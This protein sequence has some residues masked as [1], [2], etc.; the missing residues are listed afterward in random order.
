MKKKV[1]LVAVALCAACGLYAQQQEN[2]DSKYKK[3]EVKDVTPE[4]SVYPCQDRYEAL[5]VIR[6]SEDFELEFK[7]NSDKELNLTREQ[8]GTEKIY[9][10]VFLTRSAG[11]SYRGRKLAI[12]A[13]GYDK[14]YLPLDLKQKERK[15]FIVSDPYSSLR[16]PFYTRADKGLE[17][18][19]QGMYDHALDQYRM[20]QQ[21]PEYTTKR[22]EINRHIAQCDSLIYWTQI[23]DSA[24]V[25][26]DYYLA[27]EYLLKMMRENPKNSLLNDR[28]HSIQQAYVIRCN[29]DMLNGELYMEDGYYDKAKEVYE[30]AVYMRNPRLAE[31]EAKLHEIEKLTYK[32]KNKTRT[33]FYQ[34]TEDTPIS[35]TS[36]G[37]KPNS[38]GGYFSLGF[39]RQAID[40]LS[41][42]NTI[43]EDD[44][45]RLDYVA[46]VSAGWTIPVFRSYVFAFFTPF[47]YVGGGFSME[48]P[49][50]EGEEGTP[51]TPKFGPL[52]QDVHWYHAVAPEAGIVLKYWRIAVNY[53]FQYRYWI[54]QQSDVANL[55][56]TTRHSFGIGFAW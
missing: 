19:N 21:C 2:G 28:L 23:V 49:V 45:P 16:S 44:T 31:A 17:L 42:T 51:A 25:N 7:S 30:N 48:K 29:A 40:L 53:K 27:R 26:E 4:L 20:A 46:S 3:L 36:A 39:N 55:L 11:T 35:F 38:N 8:E 43:F 15:E 32:K 14:Y 54:G 18:F 33:L 41:N 1:L 12:I 6:C 50:V 24:E 5:V 34:I 37:C 56:G 10:F 52:A 9:S 47:S 22:N 13:P